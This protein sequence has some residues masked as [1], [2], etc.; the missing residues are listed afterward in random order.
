MDHVRERRILE[1]GDTPYLKLIHPERVD[2]FYIGKKTAPN[3]PLLTY[4]QF[5]K[6]RRLIKS[7]HYHVLV[8][9]IFGAP[10]VA[11][12]P[13]RNIFSNILRVIKCRMG[14]FYLFGI[15]IVLWL[16]EGTQI[17]LI[18]IDR[19]DD[20]DKIPSHYFPV[21][22]RCRKYYWRELPIKMENGFLFTTS[23]LQD[24]SAVRSSHIFRQHRHKIEPISLGIPWRD[25]Y[26]R[27]ESDPPKT[28]DVFFAGTVKESWVRESG[29][30]L[31]E[32]LQKEGLNILIAPTPTY[33]HEE[34][35]KL[36]AQSWLVWSPE[37][38]GWDCYRHYESCLA[39]SIPVINYPRVRRYQPLIDQVHAFYYAPEGDD[40][41]RVIR[42]ALATNKTELKRISKEGRDHVMKFHLVDKIYSHILS[43]DEIKAASRVGTES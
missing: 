6:L 27:I 18:V 9:S 12:K 35:L 33:S 37:G 41:K 40:L 26:D 3:K 43:S 25:S 38:H 24:T 28:I 15:Q 29:I 4:G 34:F 19:K 23:Y 30:R 42:R 16:V 31:L 21:L 22:R 10:G 36:C 1:V 5:R 17:P 13:E 7:G 39:H 2:Y 32:E 20:P 14:H 11:W 8:L